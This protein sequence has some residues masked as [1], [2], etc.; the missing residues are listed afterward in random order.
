MAK[1]KALASAKR[2]GSRYGRRTRHKFARVEAEQ[3]KA[4]KCPYC[5][6][7][8]VG[9]VA[10]G[11]WSCKKC[12]AKFTGRAY[13]VPKK[14]V[15]KQEASREEI[16]AETREEKKKEKESKEEKPKRYKEKKTTKKDEEKLEPEAPNL[17]NEVSQ[18]EDIEPKE[19]KKE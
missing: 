7:P 11:I 14:V 19:E 15:I 1:D 2:F 8:K 18:I 6:V 17:R 3:K 10:A 13:T 12:G 4:H 5:S 9:R 16:L